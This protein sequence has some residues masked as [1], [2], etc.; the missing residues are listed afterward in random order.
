MGRCNCRSALNYGMSLPFDMGADPVPSCRECA[1][2][3][4]EAGNSVNA[5][6][7][8]SLSPQARPG[9]EWHEAP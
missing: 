8:P 2:F 4:A 5:D 3:R 7:A 1:H 6:R 9:C